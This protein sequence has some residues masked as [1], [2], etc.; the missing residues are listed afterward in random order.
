[1]VA[2][3]GSVTS[4]W[5]EYSREMVAVFGCQ[6][7]P[8]ARSIILSMFMIYSS[9]YAYYCPILIDHMFELTRFGHKLQ[10]YD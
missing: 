8:E 7:E 3:S 4:E 6:C 9:D 5:R 10:D 1:M 2:I